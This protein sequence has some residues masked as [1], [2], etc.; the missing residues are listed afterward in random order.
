MT[1]L[2]TK[3]RQFALSYTTMLIIW[4]FLEYLIEEPFVFANFCILTIAL[5]PVAFVA[6]GLW[7]GLM[8]IINKYFIVK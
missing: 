8:K 2:K 6:I 4:L 3:L 1:K 5:I 7:N